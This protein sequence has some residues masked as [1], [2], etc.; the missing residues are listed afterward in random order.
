L[1]LCESNSS[2]SSSQ[3]RC[4]T[5][6]GRAVAGEVVHLLRLCTAAWFS[7]AEHSIAFLGTDVV[8]GTSVGLVSHCGAASSCT[9][10]GCDQVVGPQAM[11]PP[12]YCS[13]LHMVLLHCS[14]S[15]RMSV[16]YVLPAGIA[17]SHSQHQL[18]IG[19][20]PGCLTQVPDM[21]SMRLQ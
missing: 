17:A 18:C 3:S 16:A 2:S 13:L 15:L 7:C 1:R 19:C 11:P 20:V 4:S 14:A 5:G 9:F 6:Y 10:S 21:R 12:A 8:S